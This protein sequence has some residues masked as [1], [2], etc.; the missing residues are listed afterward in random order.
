MLRRLGYERIVTLAPLDQLSVPGGAITSLP[1]SGE[2]CDLDVH[3]KQCAQIDLNGRRIALFVDSD[4]IDLDVY[5]R[6]AE[7]L[8]RPDL[9]FVG[10][11]CFGAPLTWLYGPL[12]TNP[13]SKKNDDSRRL[14]GANCQRAARLVDLLQPGRVF[15]YAMGQ[16]PWMRYLMGLNYAE[17]SIQLV[18]SRAF[19]EHCQAAGIPAVRLDLKMEV[20]L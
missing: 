14:S 1:F 8:H 19:N 2:H 20:E 12:I 3:S 10:M 7:R 11:E 16:E 6:I 4:A 17:D 13:T 15:V 5:R 18:E 9:M